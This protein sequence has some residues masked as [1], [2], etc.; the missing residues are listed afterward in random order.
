MARWDARWHAGLDAELLN[1]GFLEDAQEQAAIRRELGKDP[2]AFGIIY[3][4]HH[5]RSNNGEG[6]MSFSQAHYAWAGIAL[7]WVPPRLRGPDHPANAGQPTQSAID[8][9][10]D[11]PA[12]GGGGQPQPRD[13]RDAIIAPREC[14]KSTWWFLILPLW[15]ACNG[16]R[17]F[18][19]AFAHSGAQAEGHLATMKLELENNALMQHDYPGV[20]LPA[21][22][23]AGGTVADRQGMLHSAGG[24]VF[25]ARGI[26]SAVLGMK[27]GQRRPD[28]LILDDIEP[29]EANY[30]ADLATKRLGT[31]TDAIFPLNVYAAVV[32][33]G[34]VTM[35]GSIMHQCVKAHHGVDVADWIADEQ[36]RCHYV[37]PIVLTTDPATGTVTEES[38]WPQKWP[39]E[40]LQSIRHTR[41]YAKNYEND[42]MARDGVY[43]VREDFRYGDLTACTRTGLFV[44]PAVTV[45]RTSDFTGLAVISFKPGRYEMAPT[46]KRDP[47]TGG[48][49]HRRHE[50]EPPKVV[51]RESQGVK[52]SGRHLRQHC[53]SLLERYPQIRLI[54]VESNQGGDL[55]SEVFAGIPAVTVRQHN[56]TTSKE[57]RFAEGLEHWQAGNV[58]HSRRFGSLEEQ[59]V[60]FPN[61]PY[62]DVIDAAVQGVRYFLGKPVTVPVATRTESYV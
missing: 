51:I 46:G 54:S 9:Q 29:D 39:I 58:F 16:Y 19:A 61:A 34:T 1:L 57:V 41:S 43:W 10:S 40:F 50:I 3:F 2:I 31:V 55:W 5:L 49:L 62:D 42:P 27:V 38:V 22:R 52:L 56:S 15:A 45:K 24:F 30:S 25:A 35:P 14:G 7:G 36:I 53:L 21:R 47:R 59:A 44:D 28:L 12:S 4:G 37:P 18:A 60:G 6:V 13:C 20:A 33:V 26:D 23:K 48:P 32:M 11:Q 8:P 17:T